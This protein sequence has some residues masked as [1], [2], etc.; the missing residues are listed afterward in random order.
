ML[1]LFGVF[2]AWTVQPQYTKLERLN[3]LYPVYIAVDRIPSLF[4]T[5]C[6]VHCCFVEEEKSMTTQYHSVD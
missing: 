3:Q 2:Q 1:R 5:I 6:L 4:P